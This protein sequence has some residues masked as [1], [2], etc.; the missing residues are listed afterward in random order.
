VRSVFFSVAAYRRTSD[1]SSLRGRPRQSANASA[2]VGPRIAFRRSPGRTRE[3]RP[4]PPIR[5][6]GLW[7]RVGPRRL[8]LSARS[9][10]NQRPGSHASSR[11]REKDE[12]GEHVQCHRPKGTTTCPDPCGA[13]AYRSMLRRAR[14]GEQHRTLRR[15]HAR[16]RYGSLVAEAARFRRSPVKRRTEHRAFGSM[17]RIA[18]VERPV[19]RWPP[20]CVAD[21]SEKSPRAH[22]RRPGP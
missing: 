18:P 2:S 21:P 3:P 13:A 7:F 5:V 10:S 14:S 11:R 4:P 19:A 1:T 17:R 16:R 15:A 12:N 20:A 8:H 6:N 9:R 22:A